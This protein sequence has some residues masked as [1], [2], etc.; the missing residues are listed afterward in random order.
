MA[1]V[2]GRLV[3]DADSHIHEPPGYAESYADPSIRDRLAERLAGYQRPSPHEE[4]AR[5]R[6]PQFRAKDAEEIL[7]R[8]N[9][10]AVGAVL[11]EDRS[12]ALDL[13]GFGA[14]LVFTTTYLD[15][16]RDF[17]TNAEVDLAF[18]MARAHNRGIVDFC[19]VDPR[20]LPVCYVPFC[21]IERAADMTREAIELGAAALKIAS[22]PPRDHS[23]S[24]VGLDKVWAQA[25][26]AGV[27]IVFHVGGEQ[28]MNP[29]YKNNGLPPVPDFHGGDTNFTS[30]SYL[31]IPYAPM[32]TL[33]TLIFDGV[34]DR[35]PRLR[36]GL[37]ELG[38]A[39]LPGLLRSMDSAAEAFRRNEERLQRLSMPPSDFVRRQVRATPYPHEPAGWIVEHTGPEV[40]MFSSDYPHVEGGR[41]PVKRFDASLADC[42][43]EVRTAFYS[44]NFADLMGP[45]LA[46]VPGTAG[47]H[48]VPLTTA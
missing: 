46:R 41:N 8:K 28:V 1:Y 12:H 23:P 33:G 30:V 45:T 4:I 36:I 11:R 18:G 17:D 7:L 6:D 48:S 34:L 44:G 10:L 14:Q 43:H 42:S 13:L 9:S 40:P 27:P 5:Q 47:A 15:P 26:E 25:E 37:I 16:L 2:E 21:D 35:F 22:H 20:L 29:V 38:A 32:Q 19:S 3:Y 39:W 24:H 31:A